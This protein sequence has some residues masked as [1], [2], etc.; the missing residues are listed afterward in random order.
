MNR[1]LLSL[2][3]LALP[4]AALFGATEA[5]AQGASNPECLSSSVCSRPLVGLPDGTSPSTWPAYDGENAAPADDDVDHDGVHVWRDNCPSLANPT[6]TDLDNDG[7]G[8]ACDNCVALS[9]A[10][11][12]DTDGDGKGDGCDPD[13]DG[14]GVSNA[15]DNCPNIPNGT[16]LDTDGDGNGN[17]CDSDDDNDGIRDT[18]DICPLV[19][20]TPGPNDVCNTDAD[21]DNVT[22]T[23]DNCVNVANPDQS[24]TDRDGLGDACDVDIDNDGVLN[25]SDNCRGVPSPSQLDSDGD[26]SG[27]ACDQKFCVVVDP[28][29]K[30]N[31][32]DPMGPFAVSPGAQSAA[33]G[34]GVATRLPIF[35]NRN[36]VAI[37]FAWSFTSRP[38]GSTA[39]IAHPTGWASASEHEHWRY[40]YP[41]GEVPAFTAD[42][43]GTY[44]LQL[45]ASLVFPDA[46]Y[47]EVSTS[48]AT[49]AIVVN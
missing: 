15:Q 27:D 48:I 46:A 30:A 32:L 42:V 20:G 31:C 18:E 39:A 8:D 29:D 13:T 24:D 37:H 40:L 19:A 9:N 2:L 47:P 25:A 17:V 38:A 14:D 16:Q 49:V 3:G 43:A 6:Q 41:Y 45:T 23:I 44:N 21:G 5:G 11:Q 33:V 28:S 1:S 12:L 22:D 36:G 26:G 4:L 34:V 10:S 35:A 7:V